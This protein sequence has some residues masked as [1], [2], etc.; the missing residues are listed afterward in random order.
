MRID[1][2]ISKPIQIK[3][4]KKKKN[5]KPINMVLLQICEYTSRFW[6]TIIKIG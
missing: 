5:S 1:H 4:K 2:I 6:Q 3:F